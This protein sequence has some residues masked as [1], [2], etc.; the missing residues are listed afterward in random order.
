MSINVNNNL[1]SAIVSGQLGLSRASDNISQHTNNIA[2]LSVASRSSQSPQEFLANAVTTQLN[3][4]KQTL[5]QAAS[6]SITTELVGLSVN[7]INAQ[8]STKVID[9]ANGTI[10]T[11]LDILA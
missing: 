6:G 3:A 11:I 1:N 2:S 8:A 5:P 9:T 4:I 7:S 10:G